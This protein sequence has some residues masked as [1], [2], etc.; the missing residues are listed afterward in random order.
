MSFSFL[1]LRAPNWFSF[2]P[3]F[4]I[5]KMYFFLVF[6]GLETSSRLSYLM[7]QFL[8]ISKSDNMEEQASQK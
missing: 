5:Y 1:K 7:H 2:H 3:A 8:V 6:E 4:V